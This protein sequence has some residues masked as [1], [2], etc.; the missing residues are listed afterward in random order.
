MTPSRL[1]QFVPFY[2]LDLHFLRFPIPLIPAF[3]NTPPQ[4]PPNTPLASP[5]APHLVHQPGP[6][7]LD[8]HQTS[9][10]SSL[11]YFIFYSDQYA[12]PPQCTVHLCTVQPSFNIVP[13]LWSLCYGPFTMVPLLWSLCH[14]P[15][16]MVP[17]LWS[18]RYGPF[19][20]VP[21]L[22][23][24]R[25]GPCAMVPLLWSL[26]YGPCTMVHLLWSLHYG[27]LTIVPAL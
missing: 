4:V 12:H 8:P 23:S 25:Y 16:A 5:L 15:F 20:M 14:G 11:Y 24:L 26:R 19:T 27:P 9:P 10:R 17:S 7:T 3:L 18:L 2:Y 22:W 21:A 1:M 13:L 6:P